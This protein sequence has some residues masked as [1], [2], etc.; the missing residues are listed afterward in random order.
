MGGGELFDMMDFT[1]GANS[2]EKYQEEELASYKNLLSKLE[3]A[4][5]ESSSPQVRVFLV[6]RTVFLSFVPL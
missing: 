4:L 3:A 6:Q 2:F 5:G 1:E